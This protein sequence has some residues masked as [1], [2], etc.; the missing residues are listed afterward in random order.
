M[1]YDLIQRLRDE[2]H[3]PLAKRLELAW[4]IYWAEVEQN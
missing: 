1:K 4:S 2:G 3:A